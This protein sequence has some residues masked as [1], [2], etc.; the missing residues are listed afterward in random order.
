[1]EENVKKRDSYIDVI[2][3]IGILSIVIGHAS[4][5]ITLGGFTLHVGSFVYLY[6]LAIFFFCSGYLYKDTV[7]DY[8]NF[9]AKK[10]KG[11]YK[12][13]F[14]YTVIYLIF[15]NLFIDM[16]I[17]QADKY[18][19]GNWMISLTNTLTFNGVGEFL[20]AFWFLPVLFFALCL[21]TAI[22]YL[23]RNIS[24]KYVREGIRFFCVVVLG[25]V[26]VYVTENQYGLLYN[27]QI[28]YLMVPVIALGHYFALYREKID[29]FI[30]VVGLAISVVIL[31]WVIEQNMGIIELSKF[32]IINRYVFYPVT[33]CGIYFCLCLGKLLCRSM[34]VTKLFSMAGCMSFDIMALHFLALK[35][36]DYLIC[37][38]TGNVEK[39]SAFPHTFTSIWLIYYIVGLILPMLIKS[40]AVKIKA[41]LMN[42][43]KEKLAE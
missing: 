27:M 7:T 33:I 18:T 9:V 36:V 8:W 34:K 37:N 3:G 10:L 28:A 35:L 29:K 20:C 11:L 21:Y 26:G 15:R 4:W 31:V 38:I 5:D 24:L 1:M 12:P 6:H 39:L 17:L 43:L 22:N 40:I 25:V 13:F 42:V 2:K 32:M 30:N 23:T 14:I 19:L 16:G 41:K